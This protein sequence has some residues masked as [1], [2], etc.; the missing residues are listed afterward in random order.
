MLKD[1]IQ[2]N[3]LTSNIYE[4]DNGPDAF[5]AFP[6]ICPD[7]IIMD[8][9]MPG[10]NGM[11]SIRKIHALDPTIAILVVTS[12]TDMYDTQEE[13]KLFQLI[14]QHRLPFL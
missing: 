10:G 1:I 7:L 11:E 6:E 12:S 14:H 4:V 5:S 3:G 2:R 9:F 13:H 8:L